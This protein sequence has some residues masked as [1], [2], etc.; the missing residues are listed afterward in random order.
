MP[1]RLNRPRVGL[2]PTSE[3]LFAG[4]TIDPSVSVPI[5]A[6]ARLAAMAAP[7]KQREDRR[8]LAPA[9][10]PGRSSS[11][12]INSA[13]PSC[14]EASE[15]DHGT[16]NLTAKLLS[17]A[18]SGLAIANFSKRMHRRMASVKMQRNHLRRRFSL[19]LPALVFLS[20]TVLET[21]LDEPGYRLGRAESAAAAPCSRCCPHATKNES[22]ALVKERIGA[23]KIEPRYILWQQQGLQV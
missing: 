3:L 18:H 8:R 4:E 21:V 11:R 12:L 7:M 23:F 2:M 22:M 16:L 17:P 1:L 9:W 15:M 20:L 14:Y 13:R 19:A 10:M 5:A 6:A